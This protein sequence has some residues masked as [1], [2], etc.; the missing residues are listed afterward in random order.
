MREAWENR[1]EAREPP[2]SLSVSASAS[3]DD[4]Q[5][6]VC[7]EAER[8]HALIPCG[9]LSLCEAC[10]GMLLLGTREP[11]CPLCRT[12]CKQALRVFQS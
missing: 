4:K 6:V 8:S 1:L 3:E 5:C 11:L 12:P 9:H 10:S 2:P 7:C